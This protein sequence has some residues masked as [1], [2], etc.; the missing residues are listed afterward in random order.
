MP[1]GYRKSII[2]YSYLLLHTQYYYFGPRAN[3]SIISHH[4]HPYYVTRHYVVHVLGPVLVLATM[5]PNVC[6]CPWVPCPFVIVSELVYYT[7]SLLVTQ[8]R[9]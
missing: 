5:Y 1:P 2:F 3:H 7:T 4:S 8:K 6:F 9:N